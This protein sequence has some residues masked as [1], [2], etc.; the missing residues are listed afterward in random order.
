MKQFRI[1]HT[2]HSTI[3][4][5]I[6]HEVEL[7]RRKSKIANLI[8]LFQDEHECY[9]THRQETVQFCFHANNNI[10]LVWSSIVYRGRE[11]LYIFSGTNKG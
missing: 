8:D 3:A 4:K 7:D 1:K 11:T 10:L 6:A 2:I 9:L 5:Y